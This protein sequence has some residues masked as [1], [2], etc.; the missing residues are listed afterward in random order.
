MYYK[1][2]L[3]QSTGDDSVTLES[4]ELK[5]LQTQEPSTSPLPVPSAEPNKDNGNHMG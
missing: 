1:N 4:K 3:K 5:T 2:I